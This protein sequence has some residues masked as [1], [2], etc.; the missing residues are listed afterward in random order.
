MKKITRQINMFNVWS[1]SWFTEQVIEY[2]VITKLYQWIANK[3]PK[4]LVYFCYIR[5]MAFASTHGEGEKMTPDEITFSKA[6]EI[7]EAYN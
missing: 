1:N 5:F 4:K 2:E 3:L 6:V 7:W